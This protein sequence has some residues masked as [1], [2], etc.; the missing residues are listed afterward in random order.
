M[1]C[2]HNCFCVIYLFGC[3][4]F[5]VKIDYNNDSSTKVKTIDNEFPTPSIRKWSLVQENERICFV[6]NITVL[7]GV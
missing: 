7:S 3:V 2:W 6:C 4:C 1:L 5:S